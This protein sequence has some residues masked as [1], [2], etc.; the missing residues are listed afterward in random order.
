M[1]ISNTSNTGIY[2]IYIPSLSS[3]L[4][5]KEINTA[6]Q[7]RI[8][9]AI[10]SGDDVYCTEFFYCILQI[11]N[12]NT[13]DP[14]EF[15]NLTI[16]D[17]LVILIAMRANSMGNLLTLSVTCNKC[18]AKHTINVDLYNLYKKLISKKSTLVTI[19]SGTNNFEI[20]LP[21]LEHEKETIYKIKS[22]LVLQE[23]IVKDFF[24][25]NT[26]RYFNIDSFNDYQSA[27]DFIMNLFLPEFN[28]LK[29]KIDTINNLVSDCTLFDF[30]CVKTCDTHHKKTLSYDIGYFYSFLKLLFSEDLLT[31][32][33]DIY[34]LQK[35]G[36]Q[37]E[38]AQT[39][40]SMERQLLWNYFLE[41]EKTKKEKNSYAG[42][43]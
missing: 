19:E 28:E 5:F 33:K 11:I 22:K 38:Y 31:L 42:A 39:L 7:K 20:S 14:V 9:K 26:L 17:L 13:V 32:Y 37:P 1:N 10:V 15:N 6:Q 29:N 18:D 24:A 8:A 27:Y 35:I 34:Y 25:L 4:P 40:T 30:K 36:I 12:E 2:D 16:H 23:N 3:V 43:F 41:D 21:R